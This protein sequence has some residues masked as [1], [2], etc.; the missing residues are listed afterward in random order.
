M[1][2]RK[3]GN[4]DLDVSLLGLGGN[5]FATRLDLEATRRVV[6]AAIDLGVTLIDTADIYGNFGD[7]EAYLGEVLGAR[8]N[9]VVLATK[10]G[11]AMNAEG[12]LK[13]AS[14]AYIRSSVEGSLR[15]LRTDRIDLYQLHQDDPDTPL[16][17]T[18]R[19]LGDL[20]KEGKVRHIGCSNLA[21]A[22]IRQAQ[23]IAA[24]SGTARFISAQD[25]Y[26]L[27]VRKAEKELLPTLA[28]QE[29]GLIPFSPLA[30]GLLTGKYVQGAAMPAGAR[31]TTTRRFADKYMT[32]ANWQRVAK[33]RAFAEQRGHT[34]LD[35]AL[36]WLAS[37]PNVSSVIAGA[38]TPEQIDQNL[39]G[40]EWHLSA[41]EM[42]EIDRLLQP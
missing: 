14:P 19:A 5:N 12:T 40:V 21:P 38:S 2:Y 30:S 20:V 39:K 36:G 9:K 7:S 37:N 1:Q 11:M 4:S 13:G 22:R 18:M 17:D 31:L 26:S 6:D 42:A 3:L 10:F 8:R 15:R 29:L 16:E 32:D 25:E 33:L 35:L 34:L 28:D 27:L 23:A 41:T 24:K